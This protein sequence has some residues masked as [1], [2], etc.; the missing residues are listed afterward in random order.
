MHKT[1]Q[2]HQTNTKQSRVNSDETQILASSLKHVL[3]STVIS[4]HRKVASDCSSLTKDGSELQV[5]AAAA[6]KA[7]SPA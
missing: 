7:Q 4:C 6:G 5:R 3:K 1:L 2:G